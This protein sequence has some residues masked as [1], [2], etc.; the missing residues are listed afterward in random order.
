MDV[1]LF[2]HGIQSHYFLH[3]FS[4]NPA[5]IFINLVTGL[6]GCNQDEQ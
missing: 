5:G 3:C 4:I 2:Q 6:N 1:A